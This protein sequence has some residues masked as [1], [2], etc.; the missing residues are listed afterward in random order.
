MKNKFLLFLMPMVIFLFF[1]C[2]MINS[3]DTESDNEIFLKIEESLDND[4]EN[5]DA[6][7]D[8]IQEYQ[9]SL[10]DREIDSI[11]AKSVMGKLTDMK[12]RYNLDGS[13]VKINNPLRKCLVINSAEISFEEY[14]DSWSERN[15]LKFLNSNVYPLIEINIKCAVVDRIPSDV[16]INSFKHEVSVKGIGNSS[17]FS[18]FKLK[19]QNI[20]DYIGPNTKYKIDKDEERDI[21]LRFKLW[22]EGDAIEEGKVISDRTRKIFNTLIALK[23]ASSLN[24]ELNLYE[25]ESDSGG[26]GEVIHTGPRGGRYVIRNGGKS[27]VK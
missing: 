20:A 19:D 3:F 10:Q 24:I 21:K 2:D 22:D 5:F 6:C 17:D 9:D 26:G 11:V 25:N 15:L 16:Y 23:N 1:G 18:K 27:Y 13:N 12:I 7:L 4:P 14:E 8:I